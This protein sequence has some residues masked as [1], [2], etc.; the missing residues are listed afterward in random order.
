MLVAARH[1]QAR[2]HRSARRGHGVSG[3]RR[4][5]EPRSRSERAGPVL[6]SALNLRVQHGKH[7]PDTALYLME[8][9]G[10]AGKCA[11]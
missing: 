9:P 5:C 11:P 3:P 6:A 7:K 1:M 2:A 10:G 8:S 4:L